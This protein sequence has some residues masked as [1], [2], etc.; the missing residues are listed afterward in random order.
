[1]GT[2]VLRAFNVSLYNKRT[3]KICFQ[4]CCKV[5]TPPPQYCDAEQKQKIARENLQRLWRPHTSSAAPQHQ[6]IGAA[7]FLHVPV[8]REGSA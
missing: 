3:I 7:R 5:P 6:D 8:T 1:M 2:R 4:K